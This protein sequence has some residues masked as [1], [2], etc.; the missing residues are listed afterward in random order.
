M[1]DEDARVRLRPSLR[2]GDRHERAEAAVNLGYAGDPDA[3]DELKAMAGD[4]DDLVAVSALFGCWQL[5]ARDVALD[6]AAAALASADEDTVQAAV[7]ALCE[8]GEEV[9][10]SLVS[11]LEAGSPYTPEILR[12]LGDI[13]GDR[14]REIVQRAAD[15][16]DPSLAEIAAGVLDEWED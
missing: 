9:V 15:S 7:Q 3:L 4:P 6:R 16:T 14:A 10:P 8:M 11:L 5:G 1:N 2:H 13:G 12:I